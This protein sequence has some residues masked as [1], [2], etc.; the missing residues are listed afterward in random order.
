MALLS[1]R[2][3]ERYRS[4]DP[5]NPRLRQ[6]QEE[7]IESKAWR[8]LWLPP[9]LPYYELG[10]PFADPQLQRLTKRLVFSAWKVV[11]KAL[12]SVLSYSAERE[13][14]RSRGGRP[15]NTQEARAKRARMLEFARRKG[16]LAGMPVLALMYPSLTLAREVDPLLLSR[17]FHSAEGRT[18]T[19]TELVAAARERCAEILKPLMT[20]HSVAE[21]GTKTKLGTGP[22]PILLDQ[23]R[24]TRGD[25]ELV[26]RG[27]SERMVWRRTL[28]QHHDRGVRLRRPRRTGTATWLTARST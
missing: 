15:M 2:D 13:M 16:R 6:L 21:A 7:M 3:I 8:L 20:A 4:V 19:R 26:R 28:D 18:P 23:P 9:S 27:D 14:M 5:G 1:W 11:P 17:D 24:C 10:G 22:R 25:K 12:A